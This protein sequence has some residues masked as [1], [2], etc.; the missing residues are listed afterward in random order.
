LAGGLLVVSDAEAD[1]FKLDPAVFRVA[2]GEALRDRRN[3]LRL[4]QSALAAQLDVHQ[5]RIWEWENGRHVLR[6]DRLLLVCGALR[7]TP[8]E[9]VARAE[10]RTRDLMH[11]A[12]R[13]ERTTAD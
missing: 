6:W 13:P 7:M 11:A 1:L 4:T 3:E 9:M 8:T 10:T 2:L 5:S 12:E